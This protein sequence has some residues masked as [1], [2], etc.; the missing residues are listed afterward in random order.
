MELDELVLPSGQEPARCRSLS[1]GTP[2]RKR[3]RLDDTDSEEVVR[4]LQPHIERAV[5]RDNTYY[6]SDGSCVL[7]VESTLFNVHRTILSKDSSSFGAMFDLPV[8]QGGR[9]ELEG[10]SDDN[11]IVL[12]GDTV[13][14]FK[15][16]LWA[17]YS[18]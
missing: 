4:E 12:T 3:A 8:P 10:S 7:R 2:S 5:A 11:P 13:A 6:F 16:F 18:L 14:E 15:N 17:L 1:P 9:A